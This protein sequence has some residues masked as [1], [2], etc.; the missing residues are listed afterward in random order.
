MVFSRLS[1]RSSWGRKLP[2]RSPAPKRKGGGGSRLCYHSALFQGRVIPEVF[3]WLQSYRNHLSNPTWNLPHSGKLNFQGL[4]TVIDVTVMLTKMRT[5]SE[6]G[7]C[8]RWVNTKVKSMK[9]LI[10]SIWLLLILKW[11]NM[12]NKIF[13]HT[14]KCNSILV[15][16][17]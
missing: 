15:S 8:M 12:Y 11:M 6:Y 4:V 16:L 2:E 10:F 14:L 17:L 7:I 3:G 9:F 13:E 5:N 1:H